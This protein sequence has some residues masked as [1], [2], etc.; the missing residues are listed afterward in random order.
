MRQRLKGRCQYFLK[1]T[2]RAYRKANALNRSRIVRLHV[3]AAVDE[4]RQHL[5]H[6]WWA[7]FLRAVAG[8]LVVKRVG[9]E[10]VMSKVHRNSHHI[11]EC[12]TLPRAS[13]FPLVQP[14]R[15]LMH[16]CHIAS[17]VG[18]QLEDFDRE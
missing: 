8:A 17:D 7:I 18:L 10:N 11:N 6:L 16:L 4:V 1:H 12:V 5:E 2:F 13:I 9:L 15:M 14:R 3:H